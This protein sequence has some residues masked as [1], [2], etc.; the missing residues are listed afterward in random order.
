MDPLSE[1]LGNVISLLV[2]GIQLAIPLTL[3][4]VLG[5]FLFNYIQKK[6]AWKWIGAALATMVVGFTLFFFLVHVVNL[7]SGLSATD[8]SLV[9]PDIRNTPE[10]QADQPNVIILLL[11][12]AWKSILTG[13]IFSILTLPFA[14]AGVAV[15]DALKPRVKGVWVR[16]FATSFLASVVSIILLGVFPWIL[17]S[18]IYLAFF[19]L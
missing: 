2:S 7:Y 6:Y 4:V 1:A 18:L 10:F 8:T 13:I 19:G 11:S 12:S 17:V 5:L 9:P 16:I 14:F 3:A 15:F